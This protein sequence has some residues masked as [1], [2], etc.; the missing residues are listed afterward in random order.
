MIVAV[1]ADQQHSEPTTYTV[2]LPAPRGTGP[3]G[4]PGQPGPQGDP[5]QPGPTGERGYQGERGEKGIDGTSIEYIYIRTTTHRAPHRPT[6]GNNIDEFVPIGWSN[7]PRPRG[8]SPSRPYEWI[9]ERRGRTGNWGDFSKPSLW[10]KYAFDGE[11]GPAGDQ[12]P[13]GDPGQ[14]GP[15]GE[16]GERGEKGDTGARSRGDF[17]VAV[18]LSGWADHIANNTTP[19]SNVIADTVTL[20]NT[21]TAWAETRS[22]NGSRWLPTDQRINGNLLVPGTIISDAIATGAVT[23]EKITAGAITS[24]KIAAATITSN[25]IAT[26]T[27]NS[28]QIATGAITADKLASEQIITNSL[29]ISGGL[30]SF[31]HLAPELLADVATGARYRLAHTGP[32]NLPLQNL[33]RSDNRSDLI[34]TRNTHNENISYSLLIDAFSFRRSGRAGYRFRRLLGDGNDPEYNGYTTVYATTTLSLVIEVRLD[35]LVIQNR[36]FSGAYPNVPPFLG[37]KRHSQVFDNVVIPPA[38]TP[39]GQQRRL[40]LRAAISVSS[41]KLQNLYLSNSWQWRCSAQL[42]LV[43]KKTQPFA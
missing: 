6:G 18:T 30:I 10:A 29:Q 35:G 37:P 39:L 25:E 21:D 33:P 12:G 5:G 14:P 15:R 2:N 9:A 19:G 3:Q 1:D 20:Y 16:R 8:I 22:W 31:A 11:P 7:A 26:G 24:N 32:N 43:A 28:N 17:F 41:G 4:P 40:S 13:Q 23:T 27:I 42:L 36:T 34:V 38:L